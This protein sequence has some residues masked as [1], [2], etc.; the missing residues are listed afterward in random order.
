M[1]FWI[2]QAQENPAAARNT[3]GRREWRSNT[4]AETLSDRG[5]DV[6]RWR[7][8]FS[9]QAKEYL[10]HGNV[11]E[12][13]DT[14]TQRFIDC[15]PYRRHV[16]F[17]RIRNHLTLGR[18]FAKTAA[19]LTPPRLIHVGNVPISL[20][21]AA[22]RY[23]K[24]VGCPVVVDIRDLWPDIYVD[25]LPSKATMMKGPIL[26]GLHLICW[27]LRWALANATA[28]T[29]LTQPYLNW[30]LE[31]AGRQERAEDAIFGMCYPARSTAPPEADLNDLRTRLGLSPQ[32]QVATYLGNISHQSDFDTVIKAAR[33]L[34][35]Q[36]PRFKVV[37]AGSGPREEQLR[38]ATQ[39]LPNVI[40]PGWLQGPDIAALLH[41][42]DIGLIAFFPVPNYLRNVPN[43]FSEY[44]A[45]GMAI[46][47]GLGGEM[48]RLTQE[49]ECGFL[50]PPGDAEA[51]ATTLDGLLS[52]PNTL[53]QMG[54]RAR[55]LHARSCD[56]AKIYPEF[57]D[58]LEA[59]ATPRLSNQK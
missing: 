23:G 45:G 58:Y 6:V 24:Q 40:V 48:G 18:N 16:G 57:A 59:L 47:C 31:L 4:L 53:A 8:A 5:H 38:L 7:S 36:H 9:H 27:R 26:K 3:P 46:A 41:L 21:F 10:A 11:A 44:L 49:A 14:Y 56:G 32:D 13:H 39:D 51:L 15:P 28:I 22:V 34:V 29:A 17:A 33:I 54:T 12:P 55:A 52:D 25:L 30:A 20:A 19:T 42:S 2:V 35:A 50:Y 1:S 37:L 43:K